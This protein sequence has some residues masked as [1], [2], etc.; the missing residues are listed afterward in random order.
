MVFSSIVFLFYFLPAV[1]ALYYTVFRFSVGLRNAFLLLSSLIFYAWGEPYYVVLLLGCCVFN[2]A[3]ALALARWRSAGKLWLFVGCTGNLG[4]LFLFKYWNFVLSVLNGILGTELNFSMALLMPIGISFFTFQALSYVIDVYRGTTPVQKNLMNV[5]LYISF[6]PQLVAGPIVRYNTVEQQIKHRT[7][8]WELFSSGCVRFVQG[9]AKKL[10]LANSFA[11]VA[12]NIYSMTNAGHRIMAIPVTLAWLGSIA[13]TLQIFFDFSAYSDMAIGLGRMFG[14]QFEENFSYPYISRSIGE[15][16][17]RW[18]I[19]LGTWFK[20]YVYIP[21]GGSRVEN[22]S[23]MINNMLI[24]WI[25]TGLWHGAAWNFLFW[26]LLNFAFLVLERLFELE[27]REGKSIWRHIYALF[28][29]NMG[30]V[31]FRCESFYQLKEYLGNMFWMNQNG[32]FSPYTWMFLKEYAVLWVAGILLCT[33]AI[34]QAG[35]RWYGRYP[36]RAQLLY[37]LGMTVVFVISVIYISKS[38]YNPFI[39]FNF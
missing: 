19:S 30:W 22:K 3:V 15:F 2:W 10:V 33:P 7:H 38:G 24:V 32:F 9:L 20:E 26:G 16:W 4:A 29:I 18:H 37:P 21:L 35:M 11:I 23:K 1:L 5:A 13:Y 17:R 34:K 27:K 25:L 8:S 14:F 6:F 31:L 12:D 39:Y 28:V 36:K